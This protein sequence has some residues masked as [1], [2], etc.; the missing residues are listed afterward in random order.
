VAGAK[1]LLM[2]SSQRCEARSGVLPLPLVDSESSVAADK[3]VWEHLNSRPGDEWAKP[4]GVADDQAFLM[5]QVMETWFMA[6][7][8]AMA[9]FFGAEFRRA[10]IPAWP[11]LEQVPKHTVYETLEKATTYCGARQYA[12]G[13]ISFDLLGNISPAKVEAASPYARQLFERLRK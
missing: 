4:E 10:A 12:K 9:Q 11:N 13:R 1:P 3:T 5:V 6:D 7:Q 8:D 2:L